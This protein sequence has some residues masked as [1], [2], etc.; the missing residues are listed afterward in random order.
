MGYN[1]KS[2]SVSQPTQNPYPQPEK[3]K[4][5]KPEENKPE[6]K[7]Y[8][9]INID[10]LSVKELKDILRKLAVNTDACFERID[11]VKKYNEWYKSTFGVFPQGYK[12]TKEPKAKAEP[13]P[14]AYPEP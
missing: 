4:E 13:K 2:N 9:K 8:D 1:V 7:F 6:K 12:E 14:K 10:L 5:R 11:L 3:K